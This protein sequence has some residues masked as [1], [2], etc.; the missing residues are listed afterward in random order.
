[1]YPNTCTGVSVLSEESICPGLDQCAPHDR[2][3]EPDQVFQAG[4]RKLLL[5]SSGPQDT[6]P[7]SLLS[8]LTALCGRSGTSCSVSFSWWQNL[9]VLPSEPQFLKFEA[10]D[11][12][13]YSVMPVSVDKCWQI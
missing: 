5:A 2:V 7:A 6:V 12:Y 4:T 1:M 10:P 3:D 11:S 9:Q 8:A 13:A